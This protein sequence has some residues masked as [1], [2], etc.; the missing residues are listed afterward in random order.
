MKSNET[1]KKIT[2]ETKVRNAVNGKGLSPKLNAPKNKAAK[3]THIAICKQL[4]DLSNKNGYYPITSLVYFAIGK[5][6]HKNEAFDKGY[7]KIDTKRA[8]T[9]LSWLKMLTDSRSKGYQ[10]FRD[11]V[12][13]RVLCRFYDK[14]S[15]NTKDFEAVMGKIKIGVNGELGT[16]QEIAK[17]MGIDKEAEKKM[18]AEKE[19]EETKKTEKKSV[20]KETKV[21]KAAAKKAAAPKKPSVKVSKATKESLKEAEIKEAEKLVEEPSVSAE[22]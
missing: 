19:K 21:K 11:A 8:K 14:F 4:V 18:N 9:I 2:L 20:K 17:Q 1:T 22:N 10:V 16:F 3:E 13:S 12:L 7:D 15:K 6:A 5:D